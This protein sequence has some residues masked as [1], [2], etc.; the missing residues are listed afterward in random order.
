MLTGIR[1]K[2][3]VEEG[4]KVE[5]QSPD[6]P[7][8]AVVGVIVFVE[9]SEQDTTEYL[10]STEANRQH[11]LQALNDLEDRSTYT[12]VKPEEL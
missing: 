9:P 8:G 10:L 2:A 3:I 1:Q 12:Y 4:G 11:L 7:T 6:V 5:I